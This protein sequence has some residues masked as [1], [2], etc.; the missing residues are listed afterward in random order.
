MIVVIDRFEGMYAVCEKEDMT[1]INIKRSLVP[2]E[3]KEGDVLNIEGDVIRIDINETKKQKSKIE[4]LAE[5][6]WK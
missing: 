2:K 5:D 1:I 6:L 4:K 3:A